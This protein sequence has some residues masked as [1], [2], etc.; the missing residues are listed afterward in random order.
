MMLEEF[1]YVMKPVMRVSFTILLVLALTTL[2]PTSAQTNKYAVAGIGGPKRVEEFL[3]GLQ[4]AVA[5][6]QRARV[7][8]MVQY[9]VNV[10][11][12]G[13]KI[14]L[15]N[16]PDFLK[17]YDLVMNRK[18]RDAI[19]GQKPEDLFANYQG[20]MIGGGEIWFNQLYRSKLIKII[21]INN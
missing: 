16:K 15:R 20:V 12:A 6:D 19:A 21:A 13:K 14:R 2:T 5:K 18:V 7:A 4:Q 17:R 10:V 9:P 11:I 3:H 8:A 1:G